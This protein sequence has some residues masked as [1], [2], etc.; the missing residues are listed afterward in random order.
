MLL[1]KIAPIAEQKKISLTSLLASDDDLQAQF[2][3]LLTPTQ[4]RV[5]KWAWW[6]H[7]RPDQRIPEGAWDVWLILAGRGW[8]KTRSGAEA[9]REIVEENPGCRIA[10]VGRSFDDVKKVM[11]EGDSGLLSVFQP[12]KTPVWQSTLK[13]VTFHNEARAFV[14]TSEEPKQL[15]G[16]QFHY[17]W[18]DE[19]CAWKA[20]QETWDNLMMGLRLG[21]HPRT[22]VTTTPTPIS[23]LKKM[24]NSP[25]THMTNG[26]TFDNAANLPRIVLE[27]L[28]EEYGGTRLGAQ[29]LGGIL[30][31]A[32]EGALFTMA[33]I[34]EITVNRMMFHHTEAVVA[35]DPAEE[36]GSDNDE[37]GMVV[38][39]LGADGLA[40]VVEDLSGRFSPETWGTQAI[41]AAKRWGARIVVETNRGGQ[42]AEFVLRAAASQVGIAPEVVAVKSKDGKFTRG[43]PVSALYEKRRVRHVGTFVELERQMTGYVPGLSKRSPDRLDA[44]VIGCT[45]LL[46][47]NKSPAI[48]TRRKPAGL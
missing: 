8:G 42:M 43:E 34:E 40:Y 35:I 15:R 5:L 21:E 31:D 22:I 12:A 13:T 46:L 48:A 33:L 17:A 7:A 14:Y 20:I 9:I 11:I 2:L 16:P 41:L 32:T 19:I 25:R 3:E 1:A 37:T 24:A 6:L 45:N 10:L 30:L 18:C 38:V 4:K 27:K 36:Y 26:H 39:V 47:D 29:E 28:Q 44:L 23:F